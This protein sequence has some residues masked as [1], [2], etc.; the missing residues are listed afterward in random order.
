M[1]SSRYGEVPLAPDF[2]QFVKNA[3]YAI[4]GYSTL[5]E[6]PPLASPSWRG[7]LL[8]GLSVE[9]QVPLQS[10]YQNN[11]CQRVYVYVCVCVY[12]FSKAGESFGVGHQGLPFE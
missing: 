10:V 4:L 3:N 5:K 1:T 6:M 8:I 12:N 2:C 7:N 11:V 9:F